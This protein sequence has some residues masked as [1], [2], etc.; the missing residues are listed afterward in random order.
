MMGVLTKS[1]PEMTVVCFDGFRP[2]PELEAQRL[3][4][5]WLK[6]HPE[7]AESCRYFG[8]NIDLAG[9]LAHEP[10]NDG[11][12]MMVTVP[13]GVELESDAPIGTID[14][15]EF[16][17][18]GI[19]GSF[20]EDPSGLWIMEGWRRLQVM[21]DRQ[22]LRIHPSGRWYEESLEPATAG[23]LRFDLYLEIEPGTID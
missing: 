12:R 20:V 2:E 14:A 16:V 4:E 10:D 22:G 13:A 5:E 9:N 7:V 17:V 11:Y 3:R 1:L 18:T 21:C 19:E 8:H 6:L 23:K 15:G